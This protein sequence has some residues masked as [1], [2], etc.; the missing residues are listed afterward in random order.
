MVGGR[1]INPFLHFHQAAEGAGYPALLIASL[2][3]L[4]VMVASIALL[5][6]AAAGWAL[7]V[8]IIALLASLALLA[9]AVSGAMADTGHDAG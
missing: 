9:G 1:V 8:A 5:A 7:A 6:L 2:V 4:A 3:A